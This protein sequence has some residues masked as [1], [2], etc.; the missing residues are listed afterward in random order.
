MELAWVCSASNYM[1]TALAVGR[2]HSRS[3]QTSSGIRPPFPAGTKPLPGKSPPKAPA[4]ALLLEQ[5]PML[6]QPSAISEAASSSNTDSAASV[7][8]V[9]NNVPVGKLRRF[10]GYEQD[11]N[12][13]ARSARP[14]ALQ[15]LG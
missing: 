9:G 10:A 7:S 8:P 11:L 4:P 3:N 12:K 14:S 2:T 6:R 15:P 1:N 13:L 5:P